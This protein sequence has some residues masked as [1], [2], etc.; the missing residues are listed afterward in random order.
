[1]IMETVDKSFAIFL[2]IMAGLSIIW[3]IVGLHYYFTVYL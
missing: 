3:T 2:A 1:M